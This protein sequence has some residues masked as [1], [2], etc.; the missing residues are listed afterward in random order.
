MQEIAVLAIAE[1]KALDYQTQELLAATIMS[2][3]P[4][5]EGLNR[6]VV[7][8]MTNEGRDPE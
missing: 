6:E 3:Y 4:N 7:R 1:L 8:Q 5:E 2:V